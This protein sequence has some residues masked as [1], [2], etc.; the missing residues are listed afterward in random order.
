MNVIANNVTANQISLYTECRMLLIIIMER[1][2]ITDSLLIN[3][4]LH[5]KRNII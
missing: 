4:Q 1:V 2:Q 3:M 5:V